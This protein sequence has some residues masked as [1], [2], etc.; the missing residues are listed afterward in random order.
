[1][2]SSATT[3]TYR[4]ILMECVPELAIRTCELAGEG[5][6]SVALLVN[7]K[8]IVRIAKRPDVV[9]RLANE[10]RL[11]PA[12]A[13]SLPAAI[14]RFEYTCDDCESGGK[15]LVGYRIISGV[16]LTHALIAALQP[17]QVAALAQQLADFLTALHAFPPEEAARLLV[18]LGRITG[19][20]REEYAAFYAEV[21][22][23]VFP[24]LDAAE[25]ARVAGTWEGY[26]DDDAN[27]SFA[28]VLI[29]RDLSPDDHILCDPVAGRLAGIIDW[30]DAAPGDPALDF[31]G[32]LSERGRDF[33][34]RVAAGYGGAMDA[35]FWRRAAFYGWLGPFHEIR[36]GQIDGDAAHLQHGL[37]SLR[38]ALAPQ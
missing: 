38:A 8:L 33:T 28:P 17:A 19:D 20:W 10:A 34:E 5:W 36:F 18:P 32:L 29:R 15:R 3:E 14:P 37:A 12:L 6:D 21:R 2:A 30:G 22:E 16:P 4:R 25:C 27:F 23:H 31:T 11:L 9:Q 1:M 7:G 26:R 35:T 24:L 13:G